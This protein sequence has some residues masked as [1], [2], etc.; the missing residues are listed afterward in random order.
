MNLEHW[1]DNPVVDLEG[2]DPVGD[3]PHLVEDIDLV[4]NFVADMVAEDLLVAVVPVAVYSFA[5][6]VDGDDDCNC[7]YVVDLDLVVVVRLE[8]Q[9]QVAAEVR[10]SHFGKHQR[11]WPSKPNFCAVIAGTGRSLEVCPYFDNLEWFV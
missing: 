6:V 11:Y 3:K 2:T 9:I 5:V 4:D 10:H 1:P 8:A 7:L